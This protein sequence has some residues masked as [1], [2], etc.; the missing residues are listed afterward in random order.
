MSSSM[1]MAQYIKMFGKTEE[2]WK[3]HT[4]DINHLANVMAGE[5]KSI[6]EYKYDELIKCQ[7]AK[8]VASFTE[9]KGKIY[10][11][12]FQV[13]CAAMLITLY[14]LNKEEHDFDVVIKKLPGSENQCLMIWFK[15][16]KNEIIKHAE[17]MY[18][19]VIKQTTTQTKQTKP[20]TQ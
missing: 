5:S 2:D 18:K 14:R 11:G 15:L 7:T 4:K 10:E 9:L 17:V 16:Y 12:E 3:T 20:A 6:Q 1:G 19:N 8:M 13:L